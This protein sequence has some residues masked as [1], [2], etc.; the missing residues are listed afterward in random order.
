MT[1]IYKIKPLYV[2]QEVALPQCIATGKVLERV[3]NG[4]YKIEWKNRQITMERKSLAVRVLG[5]WKNGPYNE[6]K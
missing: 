2:G 4:L 5:Q 6:K 3:K 1:T